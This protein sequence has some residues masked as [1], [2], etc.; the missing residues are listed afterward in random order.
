M[1]TR[2]T[3]LL[4]IILLSLSSILAGAPSEAREKPVIKKEAF[5]NTSDGPVDV[6]TIANS[7]GMEVRVTNYGGIIVLLGS[8]TR[9]ACPATWC[10]VMTISTDISRIALTS[11]RS[12][13]ATA[14]GSQTA[15]SRWMEWI[16]TWP[17]ITARIPSTVV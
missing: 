5:G 4:L 2:N 14:T 9:R 6:Y 17:K 1:P 8:R 7:H 16:I 15:N 3:A 13:G 11:A 10:S 12:S